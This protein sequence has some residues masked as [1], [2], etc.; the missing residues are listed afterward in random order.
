MKEEPILRKNKH[1]KVISAVKGGVRFV[2]SELKNLNT[3]YVEV[4]R[5]YEEAQK[6]LVSDILGIAGEIL[7]YHVSHDNQRISD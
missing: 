3:D 4:K 6:T 2:T 5:S 7:I 1:Y